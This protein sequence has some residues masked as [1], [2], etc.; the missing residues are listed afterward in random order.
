MSHKADGLYYFTHDMLED[1]SAC[2]AG[3]KSARRVF[4]TDRKILL[5]QRNVA[6]YL[7]HAD[8]YVS[9]PLIRMAARHI[10]YTPHGTYERIIDVMND[11]WRAHD[12]A[13]GRPSKALINA[14]AERFMDIVWEIH[15]RRWGK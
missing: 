15:Q 8:G 12:M 7:S 1:G 14:V 5:T 6:R 3:K 4:K 2:T 13:E 9:W 10:G 11:Y